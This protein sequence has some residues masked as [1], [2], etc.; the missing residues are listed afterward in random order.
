MAIPDEVIIGPLTRE[1][2]SGASWRCSDDFP[3]NQAWAD[4]VESVLSHLKAQKQF[5]RFLPMLRGKLTQR[6]SALAEARTAFFFSRNGF[7][8]VSWEPRGGSN[9]LGEFEIQ[10][11]LLPPIFVE[12]KGPRWEGEIDQSER[13]ERKKERKY[14]NGEVRSLDTIGKIIE[15]INKAIKQN[16]FLAGKP[17]LL[18]VYISNL[19]V[20]PTELSKKI[21]L[22]KVKTALK[23]ASSLSGVLML[24]LICQ[25]TSI[26]YETLFVKNTKAD[27]DSK[28][29]S[30]MEEWLL[31]ANNDIQT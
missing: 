13:P 12:V 5:R 6:D 19:F 25:G 31:S 3:S 15:A 30:P 16:K 7:S 29:P 1:I 23:T 21:V 9:S 17:N 10:Q 22:P 27:K 24:Y 28:L 26:R 18:V 20:S 11:E 14:K 4:D 8:I 2:F